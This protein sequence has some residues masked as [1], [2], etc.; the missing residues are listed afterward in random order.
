MPEIKLDDSDRVLLRQCPL[1]IFVAK[2]ARQSRQEASRMKRIKRLWGAHLVRGE[3][4]GG[5]DATVLK[6]SLTEAGAKAIG[7]PF[8]VVANG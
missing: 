6:V 1:T 2:G 4:G 5:K 7:R 3:V 8:V